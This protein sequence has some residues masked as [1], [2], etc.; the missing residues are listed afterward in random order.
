[1]G[2]IIDIFTNLLGGL[3]GGDP[4]TPPPP[5]DP[6]QAPA[7][8]VAGSVKAKRASMA[9]RKRMAASGQ[10]SLIAGGGYGSGSG[11][12]L[13]STTAGG[14]KPGGGYGS[15]TLMGR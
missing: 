4:Y 2:A 9:N 6:V 15:K 3:G 10:S 14:S 8:Q 12:T 11:S 5:P 13:G 7:V 1:M